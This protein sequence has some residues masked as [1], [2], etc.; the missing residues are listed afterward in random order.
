MVSS[1]IVF[2]STPKHTYGYKRA[3]ILS[4]FVNSVTLIA[5]AIYLIVEAVVRSLNPEPVKADLVIY[6]AIGS[7]IINLISVL[8]LHKDAKDSKNLI[9]QH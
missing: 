7:I 2:T 5:I 1:S 6:F 8:L 9:I 3:E 4:A